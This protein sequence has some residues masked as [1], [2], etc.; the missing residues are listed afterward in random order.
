MEPSGESPAAPANIFVSLLAGQRPCFSGN[1][2]AL[3][4]PGRQG[5]WGKTQIYNR[6]GFSIL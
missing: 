2:E 5:Q 1:A 6:F 4:A 3:I